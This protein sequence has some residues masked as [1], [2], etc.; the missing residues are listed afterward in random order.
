MHMGKL[1]ESIIKARKAYQ[2]TDG[3]LLTAYHFS[4]FALAA[5]GDLLSYLTLPPSHMHANLA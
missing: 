5:A 4:K 3:G 1:S 2:T